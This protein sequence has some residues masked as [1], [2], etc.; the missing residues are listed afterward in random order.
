MAKDL[1]NGIALTGL[2]VAISIAIPIIGFCFVFFIPLPTV[3][4]RAKLGR[5]YG[6]V[7]PVAVIFLT[8]IAVGGTMDHVHLLVTLP[9]SAAIAQSAGKVKANSSKWA[10]DEIPAMADF[11]WQEGYA[12][13]T[14]S[15]SK[16]DAAA[17]YVAAQ[18]KHHEATTFEQEFMEFL[19]KHDVDYDPRHVWG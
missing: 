4:Y 13:F 11:G 6:A 15:R 14:V 7:I 8:A 2:I 19:A 12:A 9:S 5:K 17:K 1:I 10:H 3:F 16:I 18:M